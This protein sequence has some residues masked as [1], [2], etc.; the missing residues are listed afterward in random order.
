MPP[1][2]DEDA[3]DERVP[4]VSVAHDPTPDSVAD[5]WTGG[6]GR[7]RVHKPENR[8]A[9]NTRG[10]AMY[11]DTELVCATEEGLHVYDVANGMRHVLRVEPYDTYTVV[12]SSPSAGLLV[13]GGARGAFTIVGPGYVESNALIVRATNRDGANTT[14]LAFGPRGGGT[15]IARVTTAAVVEVIDPSAPYIEW[16]MGVGE[17][18]E[19]EKDAALCVTFSDSNASLIAV[20]VVS[21]AVELYDTRVFHRLTRVAT[22]RRR[23]IPTSVRWV[24]H[25]L[26][27]TLGSNQ[28]AVFDTAGTTRGPLAT[29]R[30]AGCV[31]ALVL[32]G[33]GSVV[34]CA[35]DMGCVAIPCDS[36]SPTPCMELFDDN[37]EDVRF[38]PNIALTP[39]GHTVVAVDR[40]DGSCATVTRGQAVRVGVQG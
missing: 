37:P 14:D 7:L 35:V 19:D 29:I 25:M 31:G 4:R 3:L 6:G 10:V 5:F 39:D 33:D 18:D 1:R 28:V 38:P 40:F 27:A 15:R 2:S 26:F 30:F 23:D 12:R 36:L 16:A 11:S 34:F 8:C 32:A 9:E 20:G 13:A 22:T 17:G 24:G 21:G